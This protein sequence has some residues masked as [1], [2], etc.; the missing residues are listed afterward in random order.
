M[1]IKATFSTGSDST[2]VRG[3]YQWDIGQVLEIEAADIGTEIVE[4]HFACPNMNEAIVY[5]CSFT[6]GIGSVTIPDVCLEQ[7]STITAWIYRTTNTQ[8]YYTSKTITLPITA[9][10][11]P[12]V[13]RDIPIATSDKY[14]ELIT[15]VNEV[16]EKL[17]SGEVVVAQAINATT[18]GHATSAGNAGTAGHAGSAGNAETAG[19]ANSANNAYFDQYGRNI[20][21]T[22]AIKNEITN[23]SIVPKIALKAGMLSTS[24]S[25]TYPANVNKGGGAE[26]PLSANT[27]YLVHVTWQYGSNDLECVFVLHVGS[28][29]N[30]SYIY[31]STPMVSG[32]DYLFWLDFFRLDSTDIPKLYLMYRTIGESDT[33]INATATFKFVT[34]L[35]ASNNT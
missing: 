34:L 30:A 12:G 26:V 21:D 6:N 29:A 27:S 33:A 28:K 7:T 11:R 13:K 22:Y 17:E 20:G 1:S 25:E 8:G 32:G 18:A 31:T 15:R 24:W 4:V 14:T 3:L 9:R 5:P 23:G 10:T 19:H 35:E 2:T 16:L